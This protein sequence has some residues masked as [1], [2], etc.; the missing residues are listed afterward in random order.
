[1]NDRNSF[2]MLMHVWNGTKF[3]WYR[4]SKCLIFSRSDQ[5]QLDAF[6]LQGVK[7][8]LLDVLWIAIAYGKMNKRAD[9]SERMNSK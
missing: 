1:M 5:V 2:K 4:N 8:T 9:A 7:L 6:V 3:V